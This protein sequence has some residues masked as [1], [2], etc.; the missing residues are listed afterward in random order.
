MCIEE[1]FTLI[2]RKGGKMLMDN[3]KFRIKVIIEKD[4][5]GYH[6]YCPSFKGLHVGGET[7]PEVMQNAQDAVTL[8]IESLIKHNEPIPVGVEV[9]P[10]TRLQWG[11]PGHNYQED[12]V[13]A[14]V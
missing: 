5:H 2:K 11:K 4:T 3:T 9:R 10:K 13:I 1:G 8:Y 6:A 14:T 7:P 12:Y